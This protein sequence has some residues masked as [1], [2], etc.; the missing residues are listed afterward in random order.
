[1]TNQLHVCS[2]CKTENKE[3]EIRC[4]FC[5]ADLAI[6]RPKTKRFV[7]LS[8]AYKPYPV[9]N[10]YH[11]FDL[12]QLLRQI[13]KS[14]TDAYNTLRITL[15]ASNEME[16][17]EELKIASEDEYKRT[18]AFMNIIEQILIDRIGYIPQRI[19]DKLLQ[20]WEIKINQK[21]SQK[22]SK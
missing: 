8:D 17:P 11:T 7:E 21:T 12:L 3:S 2:Y 13:R 5:E 10:S 18:T 1:M 4:T 20:A 15:K 16:V 22:I 14:R 6:S 9:L 19:D